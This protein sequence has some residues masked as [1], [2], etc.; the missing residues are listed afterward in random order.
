MIVTAVP[1]VTNTILVSQNR[2]SIGTTE[3]DLRKRSGSAGADF[4]VAPAAPRPQTR[5]L[6]VAR[7]LPVPDQSLPDSKENTRHAQ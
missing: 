6:W 3:L 4:A 5:V 7:L 1:A 2:G